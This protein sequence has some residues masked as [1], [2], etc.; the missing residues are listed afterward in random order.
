VAITLAVSI[1]SALF[2]GSCTRTKHG[3]SLVLREDIYGFFLGQTKDAVFKRAEGIAVITRAPEP[4]LGYRGELWNFSA[5]LEAHAE[6]DHIRCAFLRD[7]LMEVIVYFRDTG[8]MNLDRLK[9]RLEAQF[10]TKA[11]AE[12]SRFEMARKTYRLAGPGM[13]ITLRRIT[14]IG[15]TELYIQY[16]HNELH[17]ELVEKNRE[18]KKR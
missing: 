3:D 18:L 9:H 11:V 15:Q 16:L 7:R 17:G 2:V 8:A 13:S 14:K 4:P 6:V 1:L 5:P 12:N 10:R